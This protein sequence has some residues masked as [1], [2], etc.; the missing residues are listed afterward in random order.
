[1]NIWVVETDFYTDVP[2]IKRYKGVKITKT[3][4]RVIKYGNEKFIRNAVGRKFF[5]NE[6]SM[7][8]F[9]LGWLRHKRELLQ[10][11]LQKVEAWL[12]GDSTATLQL[13]VDVQRAEPLPPPKP[14]FLDD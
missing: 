8:R 6:D 12:G 11:Q 7:R 2:R 5:D 4:A 10:G 3:G 1:M 9:C 13:T 14:G